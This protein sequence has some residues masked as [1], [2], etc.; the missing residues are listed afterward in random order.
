MLLT[1]YIN[2]P[3]VFVI[4]WEKAVNCLFSN[5]ISKFPLEKIHYDLWGLAPITS[6]QGFQFYAIF[7]DD[8]S[9]FIWLC[10]LQRKSNFFLLL[11]KVSKIGRKSI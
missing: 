1:G 5:K 11:S 8:Y 6:N 2:L 4:K 7:V 10:P 3:C 9:R